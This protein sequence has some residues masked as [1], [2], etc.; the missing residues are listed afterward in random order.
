M[1]LTFSLLDSTVQIQRKI[2]EGCVLE[3]NKAVL[4]AGPRI[5]FRV[6]DVV[7]KA[8]Q[9][10]PTYYSLRSGALRHDF[11]IENPNTILDGLVTIWKQELDVK[12]DV[13]RIRG[14]SIKGSF[15]INAIDK[16]FNKVLS[17]SYASFLSKSNQVTWL[18]WLLLKGTAS[19]VRGYDVQYRASPYSRTGIGLMIP[20]LSRNFSVDANFSGTKTDNF[21]TDAMDKSEAQVLQ[22]IQEEIEKAL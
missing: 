13:F 18:D 8:I 22:I 9:T 16:D 11:G 17:S 14:T 12:F 19:V 3:L 5:Q 15:T 4:K 7:V 10:S 20:N 6:Q 2:L 21:V 1:R